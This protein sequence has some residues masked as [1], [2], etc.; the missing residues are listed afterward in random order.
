MSELLEILKLAFAISIPI[1]LVGILIYVKIDKKKDQKMI[2]ESIKDGKVTKQKEQ[3]KGCPFRRRK[4]KKP[5][6][7]WKHGDKRTHFSLINF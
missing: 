1:A 2:R 6:C 3:T 7:P 5:N 4:A